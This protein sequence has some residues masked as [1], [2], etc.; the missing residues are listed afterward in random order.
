M[1]AREAVASLKRL[2]PGVRGRVTDLMQVSQK[3]YNLAVIT[4]LGREADAVVV[5]DSKVAKECIQ[6]LK[7][8]RIESM[9]FLP[10]KELKVLEPDERLRRLGGTAKLCLDVVNFDPAVQRAMVYALGNDTVV[11]DGHA[12]A[13]AITFGGNARIKVVSVDGTLI[14]KSGEMTGGSSGS[15]EAKAARF[16]AAE[17]EQ[18]RADRQAAEG[19]L[20]QLRPVQALAHEE[21]EAAARLAQLE[22]DL[23]YGAA[24]AAVCAEK[25]EKLRK[26]VAAVE[27]EVATTLPDLAAAEKACAL[28]AAEVAALETRIH[29]MEDAV[30]ADFSASVGVANIREYEAHNLATLQR[31][32]EER[33]KFTQ[34]RATL[35]EHLNFERSRDTEG[36]RAKAEADIAKHAAELERL[37]RAAAVARAETEA[38]KD[39]LDAWERDVAAAKSEAEAVEAEVK[40][41]RRQHG[42]LGQEGARLQRAVGGKTA[43]VEALREQRADLIAA[44][45]M[46]RLKLPRAQDDEGGAGDEDV[47]AL[48]GPESGSGDDDDDDNMDVDDGGS[49]GGG[50]GAGGGGGWRAAAFRAR[51][52]YDSLPP[53]LKQV[54]RASERTRMCDE[55]RAAADAKAAALARLEPNM[56]AIHQYEGI[57]EKERAQVEDLEGAHQR[58]RAAADLYAGFKNQRTAVFTAAFTHIAAAIDRVYKELT[59]SEA[60]PL[61]GT[62]YLS[63][64]SPDEPYNHG[65]K[66]TAMPP[67]KR[68][69]DMDQLSGG[70]KT[71]AALALLFAIHSYRSAPFFVLDEVDSALDKTNVE[72]M[73]AF[74]R[75]RSHG[76]GAGSEGLPCQ[77]IVISLKDDFFDKADSMVGVCRDV[78]AACSRVFTFDLTPYEE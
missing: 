53:R 19:G 55:L 67:T 56:K 46:E 26:E 31:A 18:L 43:A 8:Q 9:T 17:V 54:P 1:R 58:A 40:E 14:K 60:H 48:P 64:E 57:K 13:K 25:A 27:R 3:K 12:E 24:D 44:A 5:E 2:L 22:R 7:E 4:V 61:G 78:H 35:T 51:L 62:A 39:V 63:L 77:S 76:T 42:S 15:L 11:C 74:I 34:Q 45:R 75:A 72:K 23:R 21:A 65:V 41:L 47:L 36:P 49:K 66:F 71:M 59:H 52:D 69:R 37:T 70:E 50:G 68:F 10:L 73:A 32:A 33:A 30:Y 29:D 6:Y 20:A 28:A 16:D 38:S